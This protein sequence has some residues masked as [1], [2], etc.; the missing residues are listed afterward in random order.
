MQIEIIG[1]V[2]KNRL[3]CAGSFTKQLTTFVCLSFLAEYF[4]LTD[5]LDDE[6]FLDNLC[7]TTATKDFLQLFQKM[8]NGKFTIR[9]L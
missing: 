8:L 1:E 2:D 9:D 5:I 4:K 6:N 3:Y 7:Q